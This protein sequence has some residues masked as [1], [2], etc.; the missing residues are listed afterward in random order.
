AYSFRSRIFPENITLLPKT[1][2]QATGGN[3]WN[4]RTYVV[5]K[6]ENISSILRDLGATP[7]DIKAIAGALGPRGRD[8]GLK[9]GQKL[10]I[11]LAPMGVAQ[12]LQPLRVV[13]L[14]DNAVEA[15][16][17]WSEKGKYVTPDIQNMNTETSDTNDDDDSSGV[18]LYQSIYETALRYQM[19]RQTV[20]S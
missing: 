7:E 15:I 14:G 13:V 3:A 8:N 4:D 1:G 10:R 18:R 16:V 17:A 20:D 6:G 9:E 5:K 12:R 2:S 11:L 19:P